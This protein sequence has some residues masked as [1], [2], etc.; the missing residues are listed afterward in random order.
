MDPF[1]VQG[2]ELD[3]LLASPD[4]VRGVVRPRKALG[5]VFLEQ[6]SVAPIHLT[7]S[8]DNRPLFY[9][10]ERSTLKFGAGRNATIDQIEPE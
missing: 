4:N 8:P 3:P 10:R 7:W 9:E 2:I 6:V 5:Y 1:F